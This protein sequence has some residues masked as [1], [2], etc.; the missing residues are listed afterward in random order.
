MARLNSSVSDRV[1]NLVS[2][3]YLFA[4]ALEYGDGRVVITADSGFIG[5]SK[6]KY[7]LIQ[8]GSNGLFLKNSLRWLN[9]Y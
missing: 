8:E 6:T 4:V 7:G 3:E 1:E 2:E 9:H 5:S